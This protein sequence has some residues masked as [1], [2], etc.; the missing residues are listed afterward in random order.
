MHDELWAGV[1]LK[2]EN[3]RFHFDKM[4]QSLEPPEPTHMNV[5]LQS[6]G[7]IIDTRWQRSFYAY[8]DAFL[9]TTRS[10]AEVIQCCFGH[11]FARKMQ[12]W[13][14]D[15][16]SDEQDRRQEFSK[17]LKKCC[18]G[19]TNLPLSDARHISEHRTGYADVTVA[20]NGM[21]GVIYKGGPTK[22]VPISET[23]RID[24]PN[25]AFLARP[26][27]VHPIWADF[28]IDGQGLFEACN[29]YLG[30]AQ[31]LINVAQHIAQQVHGNNTLTLPILK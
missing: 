18:D 26:R 27:P 6:A 20:I 16:P 30:H 14:K 25:L 2:L 31:N 24:D 15:L 13:F 5:A 4:G 3:A 29:A 19:F 11:D 28:Q 21:L 8:F 23:R 17:Q 10:V 1:A 7:T 12:K 22:S 9:S